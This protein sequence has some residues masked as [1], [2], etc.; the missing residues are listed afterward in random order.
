[1]VSLGNAAAGHS[2]LLISKEDKGLYQFYSHMDYCTLA[3][4]TLK[5][6]YI[7]TDIIR[8]GQAA[9]ETAANYDYLE[10]NYLLT[11]GY[12][13]TFDSA[14]YDDLRIVLK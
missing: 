6:Q 14:I 8:E 10:Y 7:C 4:I 12:T 5:N 11:D 1:M 13:D 3:Q 2:A 9:S